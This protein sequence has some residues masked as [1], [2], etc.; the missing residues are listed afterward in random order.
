MKVG[1]SSVE[2]NA[3]SVLGKS[4]YHSY[5]SIGQEFDKELKRI[6]VSKS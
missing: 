4:K 1:F 3:G 5:E 6:G 2:K